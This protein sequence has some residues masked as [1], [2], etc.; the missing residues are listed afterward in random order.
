MN[1][2]ANA[3]SNSKNHKKNVL[4]LGVN[5]DHI[6]TVRNARGTSYPNP[7][8]AAFIAVRAGA[9]QI[10]VHLREDRRHIIDADVKQLVQVLTVPLNLEMACTEQ[11]LQ[12]AL[13]VLPSMVTLVPEKREERTTEGGLNLN[14]NQSELK[15][16]IQKLNQKN[17]V[18]S[19]FIEPEI[20]AIQCA[21]QLGAQ[22]VEFHTGTYAHL[23]EHAKNFPHQEKVERELQKLHMA[24]EEAHKLGLTVHAGHGLTL[25][26]MAPIAGLPHMNDLNIGH[27]IIAHALFVGLF[28]SVL[29]F[30]QALLQN[31]NPK[32]F[33]V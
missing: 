18:V 16:A 14:H 2:Q 26:N 8:E 20:K 10:T 19:L 28:Q 30:K 32:L 23:C 5:I 7:V 9:D 29:D 15:N 12:I 1:L 3:N 13:E 11:M 21:H 27:S 31:S 6:A 4:R 33:H 22:A 17:I 25:Q 24:C